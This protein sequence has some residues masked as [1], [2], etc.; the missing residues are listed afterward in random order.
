MYIRETAKSD[1]LRHIRLGAMRCAVT[2]EIAFTLQDGNVS[3]KSNLVEARD[4]DQTQSIRTRYDDGGAWKA[5]GVGR[6]VTG[7]LSS[8]MKRRVPDA[9]HHELSEYAALLRALRV[10]DALDVTKH[11]TKP[12]PFAL[13]D[14]ELNAPDD[15]ETFSD[16]SQ[17]SASASVSTRGTPIA[18]PS[19]LSRPANS[20]V[21]S[22]KTK[23]KRPVT[24]GRKQRRRDHWT[25]WPLPLPDV[26]IPEWSLEDEIAVV[27]SQVLKSCPS[28]TF[29]VSPMEDDMEDEEDE[30]D[31]EDRTIRGRDLAFESDDPDYPYYVP[32][33]TS[34]VANFL[35]VVLA[36]L[37]SQ[38]PARPASMQNRIEPLN[39]R[40]VID[41]VLSCGVPEFANSK[42]VENV[43]KRMETIYGPSILPLE[44]DKAT[45]FRA[46]ERMKAKEVAAEKFASALEKHMDELF[47]PPYIPPSR[48]PS[49]APVIP[50]LSRK[51]R[52]EERD[53][54]PKK[55]SRKDKGKGRQSKSTPGA[56]QTP[57]DANNDP[58]VDKEQPIRRSKRARTSVNYTEIPPGDV[59]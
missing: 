37:A 31:D 58:L 3:F 49:P 35:S 19:D 36:A 30:E 27:A 26:L 29:P 54:I 39:W 44:G 9:L 45:S 47:T 6:S 55:R 28:P 34:V 5:V 57:T 56:D 10:R 52:K 22:A 38:T 53:Y 25:R 42:V 20:Q 23:G 17:P 50:K 32:Y 4:E 24:T 15:D 43:I 48:S 11:I 7:S 41:V 13:Q 2:F 12:S 8:A 1:M 18:G 14:G 33:L 40:A 21:R 16:A 51:L 59:A 46:V